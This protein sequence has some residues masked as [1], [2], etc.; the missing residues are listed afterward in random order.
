[1]AL[2]NNKKVNLDYEILDKYEAGIKLKGFEAKA[3]RNKMMSLD[4]SYVT[5]RGGEAFLVNAHIAPYQPKNTP[6]DYDPETTRKL[7]LNKKE[8]LKLAGEDKKKGLTILPISVYN[9][10]RNIKVEIGIATGKKKHDKRQDL[11]K[12]QAKRESQ[13]TLKYNNE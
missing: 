6:K 2:A 9:K 10:G 4:G 3:V 5:I 7:L 12:K 11:K 13:R 1:M 8:L